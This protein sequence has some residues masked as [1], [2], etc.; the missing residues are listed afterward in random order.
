MATYS[1]QAIT[2]DGLVATSR[3]AASGDKITPDRNVIL[4]VTNGAG[5][6]VDLT[7]TVHGTSAYGSDLP[8]KVITI[9][10]AATK[11]IPLSFNEYISPT[12]GLIALGWESTTSVTFTVERI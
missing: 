8:D 3:T 6:D 4:R 9:A 5:A 10:A 1:A 7:I 2:T 11:V 12:D